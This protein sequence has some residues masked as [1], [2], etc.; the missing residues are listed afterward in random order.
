MTE[1]ERRENPALLTGEEMEAVNE[2][3]KRHE[4]P[5]LRKADLTR[6]QKSALRQRVQRFRRSVWLG[7][8]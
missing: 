7:E 5:A 4:F 2:A 8:E 6:E 3:A 1:K